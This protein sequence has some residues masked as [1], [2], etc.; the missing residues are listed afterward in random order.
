MITI[1][2]TGKAGVVVM[3]N[4]LDSSRRV[5]S[6]HVSQLGQDAQLNDQDLDAADKEVRMTEDTTKLSHDESGSKTV[7][8]TSWPS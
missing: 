1:Y 8:I 4:R 5:N 6:N 3:N 2:K 7:L